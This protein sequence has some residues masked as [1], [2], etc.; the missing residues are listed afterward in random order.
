MT[1]YLTSM[2]SDPYTGGVSSM[3]V[4]FII[5][6]LGAIIGFGVIMFC[7]VWVVLHRNDFP[8]GMWQALASMASMVSALFGAKAY[9]TS[10]E[11]RTYTR[12][13]PAAPGEPISASAR[14]D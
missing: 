2:T 4:A 11:V 3:R 10:S 1:A 9:Q 12:L 8:S 13:A 6:L 7:T 14:E 5:M